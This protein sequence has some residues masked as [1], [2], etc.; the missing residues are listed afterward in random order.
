MKHTKRPGVRVTAYAVLWTALASPVLAQQ[1]PS[2]PSS[3]A[4][5]KAAAAT[6]VFEAPYFKTYNPVTAADMIARV[7][8]FELRDGDDR[9]G[10]GG[11]AGNVL[12][13][14]E[15]PSSKALLS[16]QMKRIPAGMVLRLELISG[17]S[18]AEAGGQ[19]QL[20]NVVLR[21]VTAKNSPTTY[22]VAIRHL[23]FAE[24]LAWVGQVSRSLPLGSK[25]ELALDLQSPNLLGRSETR[26]VLR[27]ASGVQTGYRVGDGQ[28]NNMGVT[29]A[30]VL[31]WR[32]DARNSV[33]INMQYAPTWNSTV[34]D[35]LER[36]M[37]GVIQNQL[38][39]ASNYYGNYTGEV[40]ADWEHRFSPNVSTK[41]IGLFTTSS[42]DQVDIYDT[43]TQPST[44]ATRT[45][46]RS[47]EGGERV[48]RLTATW[49]LSKQHTLEFGGE[50]AFNYRQTALDIFTQ[51]LGGVKV[52]VPL[53]VGHARVE[54][55]RGE[56]FFTDN[57]TISPTLTL[58]SGVTLEASRLTQTGDQSKQRQFTYPKPS[59]ILTWVPNGTNQVRASLL[60]D[61]SQLDFAE[62]SSTV[63]FVNANST[64]G[65]PDLVPEQ[66][67]KAR[68]EWQRRFGSRAAFTLAAF[69]DEVIDVHDLVDI[70]GSDAFGNIGNG[71]RDGVEIKASIPLAFLGLPTAEVRFNG[72]AQATQVTDPK[73][74]LKRSFSVSP[75][76]Q[77]SP[78][79]SATLNAGN[80]DWAYVVNF[81][82]ELPK[83]KSAW[84]AAVVQW[85]GREEYK[86]AE[87]VAYRRAK[88]R[89]DLFAETTAFGPATIRLGLNGLLSPQDT[90]VRT[91][92]QG[93]RSTG[94]LLKTEN[95]VTDGGPEGTRSI[96]LQ[97]SGKF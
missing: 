60:H 53:A 1:A 74:G 25:A 54:E 17:G 87:T 16:D 64:Q 42:V 62:F 79:G 73:T 50:G 72:L 11:T 22:V 94:I 19:T 32:P 18:G 81:R 41:L 77:G 40:G 35:S 92:Y 27:N 26:D 34:T 4:A 14:G 43:Y 69:H 80:K 28:P 37:A 20:V 5:P 70:A 95:R 46:G 13:N 57:W 67:W 6:Q 21:K 96:L 10:F 55:I 56:G 2:Q 71:K 91:F 8:G 83:L 7:P 68:V 48:G 85:S 51:P 29:G 66:A 63:D 15:R 59:L 44:H 47:T 93:D 24:R 30:A 82:Q 31:K 90:R 76:R 65:N 52:R 88:P 84:G 9:R 97:V 36:N 49:R 78:S 33:N 12:I 75:E 61:V 38:V 45:Q 58:E 86:R 39:G 23:Q 89:L 3:D